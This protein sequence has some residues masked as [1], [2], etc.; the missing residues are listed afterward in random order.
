MT[1]PKRQ[2][3]PP[4]SAV[5]WGSIAL[6]AVLFALL[7]YRLEAE[8][9]AKQQAA[10]AVHVRKV[11]KRRVVTTVVGGGAAGGSGAPVTSSPATTGSAPA[12]E[13]EPE[14]VVTSSS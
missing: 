12:P 7:T 8:T 13:P 9:A 1:E 11:I 6:F 4:A 10:R 14:P 5:F 2:R 3:R